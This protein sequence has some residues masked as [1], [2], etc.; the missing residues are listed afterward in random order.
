MLQTYGTT[1]VRPTERTFNDSSVYRGIA[2]YERGSETVEK[3]RRDSS[4]FVNILKLP[5]I[6]AHLVP[7]AFIICCLTDSFTSFVSTRPV[8]GIK[9]SPTIRM[10]KPSSRDMLISDT[11]TSLI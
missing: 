9:G 8:K 5:D 2:C 1:V 10:I 3:L 11:L 4:I 7:C 6:H